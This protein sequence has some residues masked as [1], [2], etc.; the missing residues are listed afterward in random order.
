AAAVAGC[1]EELRS[2]RPVHCPECWESVPGHELDAHL[3]QAHQIYS[4]RGARRKFDDALNIV[5]E[6]V[7]SAEP[8]VDAWRMLEGMARDAHGPQAETF[9]AQWLGA[10]LRNVPPGNRGEVITALAQ[11]AAVSGCPPRSLMHLAADPSEASRQLALAV[12]ARLPL[13]IPSSL[14]A[15]VRP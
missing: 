11:T 3:Q 14:I 5:L 13:P 7:C 9:L 12:V 2:E 1:L 15:A 4:F 10:T 8:D 6:A